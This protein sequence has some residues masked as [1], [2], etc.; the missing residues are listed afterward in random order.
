MTMSH[1]IPII[2]LHGLG[3]PLGS[4]A[5]YSLYPLKYFLE[6]HKFDNVHV[7]PY[8]S[9]DL[10]I[11]ESI[12][13]VSTEIAKIANADQEIIIVGQSMGGVIGFNMHTAHTKWNIRLSISI[14]SPLHGARLITQIETALKDNLHEHQ[15][16]YLRQ[17]IKGQGHIELQNKDQ[18][19]E[20]PH[21]YKT[22]S[23]GWFEFPF[24]GCV[25]KDEA[26]LDPK[27]NLHLNWADHRTIFFN[28]RLWYHVH[29]MIHEELFQI[30]TLS[31]DSDHSTQDTEP[32]LLQTEPQSET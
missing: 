30:Q 24:D 25:Y 10:T 18:Q 22:I 8:P 20:P 23:L 14:G 16:D 29:N 19:I 2:L 12:E 32:R 17:Y 1:S 11:R 5:K 31:K 6:F 9:D 4:H 7:I 28:P 26:I 27:H 3:G 21:N 15:F 13:Y